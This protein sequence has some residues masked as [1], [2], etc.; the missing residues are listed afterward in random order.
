MTDKDPR[1]RCFHCTF[2]NCPGTNG[3]LG[4]ITPALLA[5]LFTA[6]E[7]SKTNTGHH[8]HHRRKHKR[9]RKQ[10][11]LTAAEGNKDTFPQKDS[12]QEDDEGSKGK[13]DNLDFSQEHQEDDEYDDEEEEMDIMD[14]KLLEDEE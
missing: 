14:L 6:P 13:I 9:A 1:K 12:K 5:S 8:H 4:S 10:E 11:N 3:A 7:T 2:T